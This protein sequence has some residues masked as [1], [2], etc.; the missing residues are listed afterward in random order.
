MNF[1]IRNQ[2]LNFQVLAEKIE[3][4]FDKYDFGKVVI[5]EY[6][7]RVQTPDVILS[8]RRAPEAIYCS[9]EDKTTEVINIQKYDFAVNDWIKFKTFPYNVH[10]RDPR[11]FLNKKM[12]VL[13]SYDVSV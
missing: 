5:D 8:L 7:K 6:R 2:N 12:F 1:I 4:Y 3:P 10:N 13:S 9:F 11:V